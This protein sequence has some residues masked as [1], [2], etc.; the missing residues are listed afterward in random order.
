MLLLEVRVGVTVSKLDAVIIGLPGMLHVVTVKFVALV[1]VSELTVT[2]ITPVV[3]PVGT[4]VVILVSVLAVTVAAVPLNFTVLSADE[5]PKLVPAIVTV[6]PTGPVLGSKLVMV[7]EPAGV[8]VK[9]DVLVA[10]R[11]P[12]STVILP[13][14]APAGTVVVMFVTVGVPLITA[15]VPLNFTMLFAAVALKLVPVMLTVVPTG[16]VIGDMTVIVGEPVAVTVK[17]EELVAINPP[18]STV[19]FPVV[20]PVGTVVVILLAVGMPVMLATMPLNFTMLFAAVVLKLAPEIVTDVAI[21]PLA[22]VKLAMVGEP[23]TE[24]V[25]SVELVAVCPPTSTVIFPVVDPVGTAVVMLLAVLIVTMEA[26]PLNFTMLL[27]TVAL[28]LAPVIITGVPIGPLDGVKAVMAGPVTENI[29]SLKN[30][31]PPPL[32]RPDSLGITIG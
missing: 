28:K 14:V 10:I 21:G 15:G 16:P 18:T 6:V 26:V 1:A 23:A 30:I 13:V 32:F 9:S 8:T 25:K 22:G 20:A 27:A 17:S 12:T 11:P 5:G 19:I 4:E 24:T 29:I 7:G 3:A 2:V 31:T